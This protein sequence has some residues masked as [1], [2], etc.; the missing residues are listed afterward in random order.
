[1]FEPC[2]VCLVRGVLGVGRA[3]SRSSRAGLPGVR[4]RRNRPGDQAPA[5]P[6]RGHPSRADGR[7][8]CGCRRSRLTAEV[9]ERRKPWTSATVDQLLE[10]YLAQFDGAP[11]TLTLYR[12]YVRNHLSPFLGA[13]K[14][15]RVDAEMLDAFYAE[16]RRCRAHCSGGRGVDHRVPGPHDCEGRC[17]PHRCRPLSA[18][19]VRHMH[20]AVDEGTGRCPPGLPLGR[21]RLTD[22]ALRI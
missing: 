8:N 13:V 20:F 16:L 18:T 3:R 15:G 14:V 19:T 11:N 4:L 1:M 9:A 22:H 12:A 17:P 5:L 6:A 10:R 7:A 21:E 2:R